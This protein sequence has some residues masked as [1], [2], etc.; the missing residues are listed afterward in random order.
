MTGLDRFLAALN[1]EQPDRVPIWELIIN[2]PTLSA[3]HGDVGYLEFCEREGLDGVTV[4]ENQQT[5]VN[6]DGSYTDEWGICWQ[7]AGFGFHYPSG[8][9]IKEK[10]DL[11]SYEPPEPNQPHRFD[12]LRA[13]LDR[14]KGEKAIIFLTHEAFEFSHYL[15]GLDK[16]MIDYVEDPDFVHELADLVIDYKIEVAETAIDLGADVIVSGDDYA[17]RHG[18]IMSIAHWEEY[19]LPYLERSVGAVHRKGV[20]YIKHTDGYIWGIIDQMVEAGIDAID[21]IEPIARMDIGE[22]KERYGDRLCVV[23]NVDCT[24]ILTHS[25]LEEVVDAVKETIAKGSPGGGHI[26]ASSNSIH[27]GVK[28]ENYRAMVETAR[29]FGVYPLD[30]DMVNEYSKRNYIEKYLDQ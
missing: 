19:S 21:P 8:G 14:F 13:A 1:R 11:Q 4:F 27:P 17:G 2:E 25:P 6:T 10:E 30:A 29:K 22:V 23:G 16:L 15:R 18:T 3:L 20:P 24:E 7:T 28:P 9:P 5:T 26:L 12:N